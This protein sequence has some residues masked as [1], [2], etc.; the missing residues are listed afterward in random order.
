MNRKPMKTKPFLDSN[1][2]RFYKNKT[3]L[4]KKS[5]NSDIEVSMYVYCPDAST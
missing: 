3:C 5:L 4:K 2:P 1:V